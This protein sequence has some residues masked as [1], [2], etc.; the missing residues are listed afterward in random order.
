MISSGDQFSAPKAYLSY[1]AP[2]IT[3]IEGCQQALNQDP[4]VTLDC[5]RTG[6]QRITLRGSNFGETAATVLIGS[7]PC[8]APTH[9]MRTQST[10]HHHRATS[11]GIHQPSYS[12]CMHR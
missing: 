4:L 10:I 6:G 12:M 7:V 1:A 2:M 8:I 9:G 11:F 5:M 3:S